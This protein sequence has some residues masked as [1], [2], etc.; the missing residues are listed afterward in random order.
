MAIPRISLDG[1]LNGIMS[2][3]D[4]AAINRPTAEARC[5]PNALYTR[6]EALELERQRIFFTG[7]HCVA[8]GA[9]VP[10]P[11]DVLPATVAGAPVIVARDRD[12][13]LR[14]FHN[15]CRHRGMQLVAAPKRRLRVFVCP[16]HGWSYGL[17]GQLRET[18]HFEGHNLH[19]PCAFKKS[20]MWL[21]EIRLECWN[22]L[23]FV[24]LSG[25][26]PPLGRQ[27][28][29][30][31]ARWKNYDF[32]ALRHVASMNFEVKANWKLAIEN[33]LES[34]HLPFTHPRLNA[35]SR[36]ELHAC[37]VER[38]YLGQLSDDYRGADAGH[39][40]LPCFPRLPENL[41]LR[42]EYPTFMPNLM[43]GLHPDYFFVFTVEPDGPERTRETFH[44]YFVGEGATAPDYAEARDKA[45]A[46]WVDTNRE[47]IFVVEGMH[48]G[49]HS[50]GYRD[51]RFS[52][53][54]ETTTHAFQRRV[55]NLLAGGTGTPVKSPRATERASPGAARTRAR[56][57]G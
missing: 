39:G 30:L 11:G 43:L 45:I 29:A 41:L 56:A 20:D 46:L 8:V 36:M 17:D 37:M 31:D 54:H 3:R 5:L 2:A 57:K 23:V 47:D 53:H 4:L 14:A 52:P 34:Y 48:K 9:Q 28:A 27:F 15:V 33:F 18:P 35:N 21:R 44:F 55:A 40:A 1:A 26:A 25:D 12:R 50:P 24:N 10:E 22:D 19:E 38:D 16:Y 6:P 13:T 51:A 42:A 49:R 7:W 32:G